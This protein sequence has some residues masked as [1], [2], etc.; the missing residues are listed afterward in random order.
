M[1]P[2]FLKKLT[3]PKFLAIIVIVVLILALGSF[4]AF[5]SIKNG[6]SSHQP[7]LPSFAPVDVVY[8]VPITLINTQ[9]EE[10]PVPFQQM[11]VINSSS[12]STHEASGLQNVEFFDSSG[13]IIP[14]W[15]ESGNTNSSTA[16]I[17]WLKLANGISA[18]SNITVYM[19]CGSPQ[20]NFFNLQTTG[21]APSLS[22]SYGEYDNGA[23]VFSVYADFA[24]SQHASWLVITWRRLFCSND[25]S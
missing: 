22:P 10:T 14:S 20:T 11:I 17:Y 13:A 12:Y 21:E 6:S 2:N 3:K 18:N 16:T 24:R 9:S 1:A 8:A 4:W 19:G 7:A 5:T 15:L 23:N 25:W